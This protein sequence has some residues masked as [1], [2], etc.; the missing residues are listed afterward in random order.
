VAL[1]RRILLAGILA[2][3]IAGAFVS[4]V[5][6]F[7]LTPLILAA[8]MFEKHPAGETNPAADAHPAAQA[9]HPDDGVA[10]DHGAAG[11][12]GHDASRRLLTLLA[13]LVVG[14]GFGLVMA[15]AFALRQAR[16]GIVP[17]AATGLLWGVAGFAAFSAAP[18]LGLP[19]ELPGSAAADLVSR[20][21]W[22][23]GTAAATLIGLAALGYG[24][25]A[26]WR[27]AGAALLI[28]PHL[29]GAPDAPAGEEAT[30]PAELAARF[31]AA[32]L[33]V[34]GLFW[35]VLGAANGWLYRRL[36]V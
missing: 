17:D 31:A 12:E 29:L 35:A 22:W 26:L 34:A 8:E 4:V 3:L 1:A 30:V 2:G 6:A 9:G 16:T 5:Q 18:A 13:N 11:G 19:P 27:I 15:G 20:Q 14:A 32:S 25:G 36:S 33:I 21:A 23:L 28:A 7:K 10:H 24:R